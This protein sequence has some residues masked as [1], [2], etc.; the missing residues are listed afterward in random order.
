VGAEA[1]DDTRGLSEE[2]RRFVA[3]Q[4]YERSS[5]LA[6]VRRSADGLAPG[7]RVLDLGAGDAPYRELFEHVEYVT[8]DWELSVHGGA[9]ASDVVASGEEIPLEDESFDAALMTQVLE[10]VREPARVLGELHRVLR[11][12]GRLFLTVPLVWELHELPHDFYRY[13]SAGVEHLLGG[14]GFEQIE[15]HARNDCFTTLAQLMRN[16]AAIMGS[17]EDG[18]DR[19]RAAAAGVLVELAEQIAELAPL[20]ARRVLPLGYTAA[21]VRSGGDGVD[22]L[23]GRD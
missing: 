13:T 18:L 6:F 9:S 10:H 22:P 4:P 8:L 17:A 7:S 16:I 15:L 21:A 12:S 11:P 5:I 14:A 2:L 20:D 1:T 19:R 23:A 3:E